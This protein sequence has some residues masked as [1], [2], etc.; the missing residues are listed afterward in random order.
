M[1]VE[2]HAPARFLVV[3][4]RMSWSRTVRNHI[5]NILTK[6]RASSRLEAVAVAA[7]LGIIDSGAMGAPLCRKK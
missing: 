7:R 4:A 1:S 5:R 3:D 2:A 6:L